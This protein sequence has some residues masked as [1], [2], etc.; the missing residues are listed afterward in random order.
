MTPPLPPLT[1]DSRFVDDLVPSP[2]VDTRAQGCQ[3]CILVLHYTGLPTFERSIEVLSDPLC[4]VSCHY[5]VDLDGRTV[6]M[7]PEA[8]RAWHAGV[9]S[10][11]GQTDLNS[12]SVGIEIQNVG[13]DA[14]YPDFPEAQM[15]AVER[16]AADIVARH[17][18]AT[19]NVVAHSDIA[20]SRKIDPGEKFD[21]QRLSRAGTGQES[22]QRKSDGQRAAAQRC[23]T[24]AIRPFTRAYYQ[25][26]HFGL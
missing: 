16:L 23:K 24:K 2:N 19:G 5:V 6:Q 12:L 20:P 17:A 25:L 8:V 3:P 4:K 15:R 13:H 14:G 9:S 11:R 10:W 26:M 7:V 1:A 21:W 18:I 22:G